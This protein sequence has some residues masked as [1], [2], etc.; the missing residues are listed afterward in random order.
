M[1][2]YTVR[3][4]GLPIAGKGIA[5]VEAAFS[6]AE[7]GPELLHRYQVAI[8]QGF[9]HMV[10]KRKCEYLA[11]R[12]CGYFAMEKLDHI[13]PG[14][15][16]Q[17]DNGC[18]VW[19]SGVIGSISHTNRY[20][21]ACVAS[22]QD[23]RNVGIDIENIMGET[24]AH[25]LC[26]H[27]FAG[28]DR[29]RQNRMPLNHYATLIFSAKEALF[30]AIYPEVGY[31]FGFSKAGLIELDDKTACFQIQD[32]LSPRWRKGARIKVAF[33]F[34]AACVYTAVI[35]RHCLHWA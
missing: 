10:A 33:N 22:N 28:P 3:A 1:F 20:A 8:P 27:L 32:D 24:Q 18:P 2:N 15:I 5:V 17:N 4:S 34:T 16:G 6:R 23:Y 35:I 30:K 31:L 21:A 7:I 14:H 29:R 12:L 13:W 19:P 26:T 25:N 9:E 11:G